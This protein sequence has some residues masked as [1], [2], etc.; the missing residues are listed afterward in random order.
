VDV[1]ICGA[2]AFRRAELTRARHMEYGGALTAFSSPEDTILAKLRWFR[3]GGEVSDRQWRDVLEVIAVQDDRLE[4]AYLRA[5]AAELEVA[6]L[7]EQ[8]LTNAHT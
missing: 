7:L 6:D 3:D 8:A 4:L 5:W 2:N 1:F